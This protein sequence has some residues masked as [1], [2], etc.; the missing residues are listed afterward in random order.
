MGQNY[1]HTLIFND[2]LI[3][4]GPF[5]GSRAALGVHVED[6]WLQGAPEEAQETSGD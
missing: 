1:E 3:L 2:V 5:L 4:G 6:L